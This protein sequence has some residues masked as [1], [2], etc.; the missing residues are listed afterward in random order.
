[1]T[2]TVYKDLEQGSDEWHSARCGLIAASELDRIM[3]PGTLKPANNDKTRQHVYELAAQRINQYVEPSYVGDNM[4]RGWADEIRAR[5]LY[6]ERF[7]PVVEVGGMCRD[8]GTFKL[9]CSPDGLIGENAGIEVKSRVQKYQVQTIVDNVVPQE[10]VLQVQANLLVSGRSVWKYVSY[11]GGMPMWII[12]VLPDAEIQAAII[13][14]CEA[15]E[16]KVQEVMRV[17]RERIDAFGDDVIM[18]ERVVEQEVYL[19]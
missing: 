2:L 8:F 7:E 4:L 3:T 10:H 12:D 19:G 16:A 18:T 17:Y 11:S 5:D 1:M 14:A 15:F 9:W 13:S 6:S